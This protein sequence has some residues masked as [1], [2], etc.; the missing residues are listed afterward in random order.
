MTR[1]P[2]SKN[3]SWNR[4]HNFIVNLRG[5]VIFFEDASNEIAH[6]YSKQVPSK[7]VHA[8]VMLA[9][10][11]GE[12]QYHTFVQQRLVQRTVPISAPIKANNWPLPGNAPTVNKMK[13]GKSAKEGVHLLGKL[14]FPEC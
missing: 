6:L 12:E 13:P 9:E 3:A 5:S 8:A 11:K 7:D 14:Y 4:P 2:L 1:V 10:S